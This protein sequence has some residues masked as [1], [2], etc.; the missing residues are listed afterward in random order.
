MTLNKASGVHK[1]DAWDWKAVLRNYRESGRNGL[2]DAA[3]A[4]RIFV[5][6]AAQA[7]STELSTML[8][9]L[10]A[11]SEELGVCDG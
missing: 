9:S 7:G 3:T 1:D 4:G 10:K 11:V 5:D 2:E 8:K 6:E